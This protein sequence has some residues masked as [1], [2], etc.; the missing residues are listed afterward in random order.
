MGDNVVRFTPKADDKLIWRC[1]CGCSTH[2]HYIDGT[3]ECAACDKVA[4][5]LS[6]EWRAF[7]P[8][9]PDQPKTVE[10]GDDAVVKLDSAESA[11]RRVLKTADT[12]QMA[13]LMVFH[14]DGS[15]KAWG[16]RFETEEQRAWLGRKLDQVE[17]M[18]TEARRDI[19]G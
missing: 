9:P 16:E 17:A 10:P 18:L 1:A 11:I 7:L 2:Y 15:I 12:D 6:G 8:P 4:S 5:S 13:A 3:V 19:A 14:H